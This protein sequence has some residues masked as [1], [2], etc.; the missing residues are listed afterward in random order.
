[1]RLW[2][3]SFKYLDPIGL[4]AVWREAILAKE[5]LENRTKGYKNHP[6]LVRFKNCEKPLDA[7]NTY[8]YYIF[9]ESKKRGYEFNPKKIDFD[10]VDKKLKIPVKKMQILY[11][12]SLLKEKLKR[13]NFDYFKLVEDVKKIEPNEFFK[14]VSGDI[15]DWE[16]PKNF[17]IRRWN[18]IID[19]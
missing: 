15:E 18:K 14:V 13:R 10:K 7:I 9:L 1:M 19:E 4:V 2:S 5:V 6:Q 8:L 3:I 11:E 16:R 12:F 17:I